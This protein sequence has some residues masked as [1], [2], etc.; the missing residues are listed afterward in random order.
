MAIVCTPV[1]V[2]PPTA[3]FVTPFTMKKKETFFFFALALCYPI[4]IIAIP[5]FLFSPAPAMTLSG[6]VEEHKRS[7]E[8]SVWWSGGG[9][10]PSRFLFLLWLAYLLTHSLTHSLYHFF[11]SP[12]LLFVH[13][14]LT[15]PPLFFFFS[16]YVV[17]S[18]TSI[19]SRYCYCHDVSS[20]V[21]LSLSGYSSSQGF[22]C[23]QA[24]RGNDATNKEE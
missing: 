24:A 3:P 1:C 18:P 17:S 22:S 23:F 10:R 19:H 16:S 5:A 8:H 14:E 15:V 9:G 12:L 13:A 6:E 7:E 4:L 20:N 21:S 11:Y 2:R